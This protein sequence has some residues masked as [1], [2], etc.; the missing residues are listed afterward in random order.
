MATRNPVNS[1]VEVDSWNPIIYQVLKI[2]SILGWKLLVFL[3]K[4]GHVQFGRGHHA[5]LIFGDFRWRR[6]GGTSLVF[7]RQSRQ[8]PRDLAL[9]RQKVGQKVVWFII[10]FLAEVYNLKYTSLDYLD[11]QIYIY[12]IIIIIMIIIIIFIFMYI[13]HNNIYIYTKHI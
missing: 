2:F 7:R 12:I 9:L 6:N 3:Q 8:R 1:P 5:R 13:I 4:P 10:F 11:I